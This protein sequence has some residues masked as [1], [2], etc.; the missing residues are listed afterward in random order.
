MKGV[1]LLFA[2]FAVGSVLAGCSSHPGDAPPDTAPSCPNDLPAACP[3]VVPS[4]KDDVAFILDVHCNR[5]HA[6]DGEAADR[7]LTDYVNV[8][9]QRSAVLNQ[10][11]NCHMPPEPE[12][13]LTTEQRTKVLAWLVCKAPN[14]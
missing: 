7:P 2:S 6:V 11:Y 8:Y 4:Y 1:R 14:N 12:R 9:R 10:I 3:S 5:C 13:P